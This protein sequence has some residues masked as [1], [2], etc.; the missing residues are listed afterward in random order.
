VLYDTSANELSGFLAAISDVSAN[1]L[2]REGSEDFRI[3]VAFSDFE[4]PL[5][6]VTS[7]MRPTR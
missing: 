2:Q 7:R 4:L 6:Q 5:H 3:E 1:Q